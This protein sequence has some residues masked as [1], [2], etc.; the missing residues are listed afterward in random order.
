[1]S[2]IPTKSF[3]NRA[4]LAATLGVLLPTVA[5]AHPFHDGPGN[6]AGGMLHPL[7]GLDHLVALLAVGIWSAEQHGGDRWWLP[8]TFLG[9][10]IVGAMAGMELGAISFNEH[11]IVSSVL[12]LGGIV[13]M[14]WRP[15]L[16]VGLPVLSIFALAHGAAHGAEMPVAGSPF[17]FILGFSLSAATIIAAGFAGG[18]FLRHVA[19]SKGVRIAGAA[20]VIAGCFLLLR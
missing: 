7:V 1:M 12:V 10:M 20:I 9:M 4:I 13:A 11:L 19:D 3:V 17:G 15:S 18:Q 16:T 6:L 14:M 8:L 5:M 2:P